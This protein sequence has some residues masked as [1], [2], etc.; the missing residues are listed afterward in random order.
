MENAPQKAN[1]GCEQ[2]WLDV[3]AAAWDAF[4]KLR[5][6]S[7][8]ISE[9]HF[10]VKVVSCS[11]CDQC[12][13]YVFAEKIDWVD[14]EDPQYW[15]LLPLTAAEAASLVDQRDCLAE[16]K[17]HSLGTDRRCLR[18]D[19]LKGADPKTYWVTGLSVGPHD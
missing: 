7:R 17:L 18:R 5:V 14:G 10:S 19:Y 1:F 4:D 13:L 2:C 16:W 11:Q 12:F 3:A 8:L 15:T 6:V 9:S